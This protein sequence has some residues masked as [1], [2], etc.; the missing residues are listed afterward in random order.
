ME[1]V[2]WNYAHETLPFYIIT[3]DITLETLLF[4]KIALFQFDAEVTIQ[5]YFSVTTRRIL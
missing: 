2:Q 3:I 4:L 1:C 5:V